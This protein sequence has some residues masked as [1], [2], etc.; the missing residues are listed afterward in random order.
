LS[1]E[2]SPA[3]SKKRAH[4]S[5]D[6][7]HEL[8]LPV[9][10]QCSE[11]DTADN[12]SQ[13]AMA[14]KSDHAVSRYPAAALDNTCPF[15]TNDN[16]CMALGLGLADQLEDGAQ[17]SRHVDHSGDAEAKVK[18]ARSRSL[19]INQLDVE[20]SEGD[21]SDN[22]PE[23]IPLRASVLHADISE[24]KRQNQKEAKSAERQYNT[25]QNATSLLTVGLPDWTTTSA[26]IETTL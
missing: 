20:D 7:D 6:E 25:D 3:L 22:S 4:F 15:N 18:R 17:P 19:P 9:A 16:T 2:R 26:Q 23:N 8:R 13:V 5:M 1:R 12:R 21:Q 10:Y 24:T 11:P 14:L